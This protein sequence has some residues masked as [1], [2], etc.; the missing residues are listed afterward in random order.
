MTENFRVSW[1][2]NENPKSKV[3]KVPYS[4]GYSKNYDIVFQLAFDKHEI[5]TVYYG[6]DVFYIFVQDSQKTRFPL[7][8]Y[9]YDNNLLNDVNYIFNKDILLKYVMPDLKNLITSKG[10]NN[11]LAYNW[12]DRYKFNKEE[13]LKSYIRQA[14]STVEKDSSNYY[15]EKYDENMKNITKYIEEYPNTQFKIFFPP[16]SIVNW[17]LIIRAGKL[18]D[19]IEVTECVMRDLLKYENVELY[20]FQNIDEIITNL[21]NYK[22]YAHYKEEINYYIF[23][24]MCKTGEHRITKENYMQEI[25]KMNDIV[26]NYD[27]DKLFN[28]ISN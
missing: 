2:E 13:V 6:I 22:D 15:M 25:K 5:E 20:Y 16:Y 19:A 26:S 3:V 11:D 7:P 4:G 8:E 21:D 27:Y 18:E 12:N 10:I 9:L 24:S 14:A 23:E 28:N 1:F 17:D